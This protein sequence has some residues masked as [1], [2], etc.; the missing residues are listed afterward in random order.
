MPIPRCNR[1][2]VFIAEGAEARVY[3][4]PETGFVCRENK[5][6]PRDRTQNPIVVYYAN[7]FLNA[8]HPGTGLETLGARLPPR[9]P[10]PS[11]RLP[12]KPQL[13]SRFLELDEGHKKYVKH[14]FE[15][16]G[17][18]C[19]ECGA[20]YARSRSQEVADAVRK[21]DRVGVGVNDQPENVGF[22]N[23]RVVFLELSGLNT[24]KMR[25]AALAVADAAKRRKLLY[26]LTRIETRLNGE[27]IGR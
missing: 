25:E 22:V 11:R 3:R 20:H 14:L 12:R 21:A 23:N 18:E 16:K 8:F 19:G 7:K 2:K 6:R 10:L 24:T 4:S 9:L 15:T 26:Y 13:Y 1:N 17:C 5:F 27:K